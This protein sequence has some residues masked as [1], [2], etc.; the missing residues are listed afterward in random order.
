MSVPDAWRNTFAE[1]PTGKK[2]KTPVK[3]CECG[4]DI[5]HVRSTRCP[6]CQ[7]EIKMEAN[8]RQARNKNAQARSKRLIVMA[9]KIEEAMTQAAS[10]GVDPYLAAADCVFRH[11][12][13]KKTS[14]QQ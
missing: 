11:L 1:V 3:K 6:A 2:R 10:E 8:R 4:A 5:F 13:A 9:R 14:C 7:F 12:S